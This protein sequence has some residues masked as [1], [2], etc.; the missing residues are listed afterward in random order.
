MFDIE[1][2]DKASLVSEIE[3]NSFSSGLPRYYNHVIGLFDKVKAYSFIAD[4]AQLGLRSLKG[5]ED[6]EVR[7]E[8]LQRLF[9][10]LIHSSRFQ[11]AYSTLTRQQDAAL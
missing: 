6:A 3:R 4:F 8:L 2:A 9:T 10:A 1:D 7:N 5:H 11:E